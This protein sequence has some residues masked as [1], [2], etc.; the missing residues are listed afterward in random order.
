MPSTRTSP[1]GT[2]GFTLIELMIAVVVVGILAAIALPNYNE[3]RARGRRADVKVQLLT[4]KQWMERLY[5]ESYTYQANATGTTVATLL[6]NQA[7]ST[8]PRRGDGATAYT[9][10]VEA[11]ANSYTLTATRTGAA[12]GDKCGDFTLTNTGLKG[13]ASYTA[14]E[15]SARAGQTEAEAVREA[16]W[17]R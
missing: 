1:R 10:T 5:T 17:G 15:F 7:F 9:I 3:Q 4:A 16:C 11:T 6:A 8:S 12:S 14:D 2:R 13:N